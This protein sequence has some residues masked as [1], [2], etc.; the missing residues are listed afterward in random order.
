M[1][2]QFVASE[3][4]GADNRYPLPTGE[5][6]KTDPFVLDPGESFKGESPKGAANPE[7]PMTLGVLDD[8]GRRIK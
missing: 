5:K 3:V 8:R 6:S 2:A 1:M 7:T 4:S